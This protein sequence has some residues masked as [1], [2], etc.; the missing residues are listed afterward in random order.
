MLKVPESCLKIALRSETGMMGVKWRIWQSELLLLTRIKSHNTGSLC[1]QVYEEERAKVWP[2]LGM[3]VKQ[4]C[5]E[6]EI[7][8]LTMC[9]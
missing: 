8:A 5:E 1:R 9:A 2:G 6:L 7:P 3:E 4:I